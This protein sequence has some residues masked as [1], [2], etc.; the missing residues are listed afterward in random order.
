MLGIGIGAAAPVLEGAAVVGA[1]EIA[2]NRLTSWISTPEASKT[3]EVV[4]ASVALGS[5][6]YI[7]L[8]FSG[9]APVSSEAIGFCFVLAGMGVVCA[10]SLHENRRIGPLAHQVDR[11]DAAG[12]RVFAAAGRV[13]AGV[14]DL[15]ASVRKAEELTKQQ[16]DQ[17]DAMTVERNGLQTLLTRSQTL[18]AEQ[19]SQ[20]VELGSQV[21]QIKA[22]NTR[23]EASE[24]ELTAQVE[25]LKSVVGQLQTT[26]TTIAGS[27]DK[28][29]IYVEKQKTLQ[30]VHEQLLQREAALQSREESLIQQLGDEGGLGS[31][32]L[33]G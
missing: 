8:A 5:L 32:W 7:A 2:E 25:E 26:L 24:R 20:L 28:M 33:A 22:E 14:N 11:V 3:L 17:I 15:E 21:E 10:I 27:S 30:G 18:A 16:A 29:A 6:L 23:L 19:S 31:L 13:E 4:A 9:I 1:I 12:Q